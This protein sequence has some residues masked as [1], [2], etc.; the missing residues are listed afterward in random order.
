MVKQNFIKLKSTYIS[1]IFKLKFKPTN[2]INNLHKF[3]LQTIP[4]I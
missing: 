2:F 1:D 4:N 3:K